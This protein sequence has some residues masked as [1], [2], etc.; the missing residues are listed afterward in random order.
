MDFNAF[1]NGVMAFFHL[2]LHSYKEKQ[3]RRRLDSY[4]TKLKLGSYR[5]LYNRLVENRDCYEKFLDYL[6]INVSEFFR[7]PQR[8]KEL[9]NIYI[10]E[11]FKTR[12]R[13]K[14]WS[15]AC[16][17]GSEPYSIAI[18]TEEL[19]LA[20]RSNIEATDID[21]QILKKAMAGSYGQESIKNVSPERLDRFFTRQG[22]VY[23]LKNI[24][25]NKVVFRY[26]N[27]LANDY[28]KGYDLIV[29]R[30]VTIY[31]TR[32]AQ[33]EIYKK[34][35]HSLNAGGILFI[36]GS[37][38]IFNYKEFGFQKLSPCFYKKVN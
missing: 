11:L 6:T 32:E 17:N 1:K 25:K 4:L 3:L 22:N 7:D 24:I 12:N 2:D 36:G 8:F 30:N 14:I 18:I 13:V 19:G 37:E 16:S 27:L 23:I 33:D 31:F 34:F 20:A 29:C 38:M 26:H 21:R 35:S 28:R 5:E 15:A 9:Q 10:P